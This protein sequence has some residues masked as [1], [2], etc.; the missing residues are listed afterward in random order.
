MSIRIDPQ[1][2]GYL[3]TVDSIWHYPVADAREVLER[4]RAEMVGLES[5][6]AACW[7]WWT[8]EVGR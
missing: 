5:N 4:V 6:T 3:V 2:H 7:E 8:V 1:G